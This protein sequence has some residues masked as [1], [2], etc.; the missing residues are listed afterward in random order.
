MKIAF[1]APMKPPTDPKPS[2]DRQMARLL[3]KALTMAGHKV[4]LASSLRSRDGKGDPHQQE[5]IRNRAQRR[6]VKLIESWRQHPAQRPDLWFTYHLYYKA[7]D[8][9]GPMVADALAIPY[10]VAEAS[11][12]PKRADGPWALNYQGAVRAVERADRIISLNPHNDTCVAA[13]L[14]GSGR[15]IPL[16]PFLD[17]SP[18]APVKQDRDSN[19]TILI[20]AAMMREGDKQRSYTVLAESL[21]RLPSENWRLKIIG[22]GP[23]RSGI[24]PMFRKIA[25]GRVEFLG[26]RKPAEIPA[27]LAT[28]DIFVWPAIGEAYGMALLEAQAA[29]LPVIAGNSGGVSRIV[30]DG[31]TGLLTP[32]GDSA[33]FAD[34]VTRLIKTPDQRRKMGN[35]ALTITA[36][37]HSLAGAANIL[38]KALTPLTTKRA[39]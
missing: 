39:A 29:G 7:P 28:A 21:S 13:H 12:A 34:A 37:D 4:T 26:R 38:N 19:E 33:A 22:D 14:G 32:P 35:E 18:Y 1:Y 3:M 11:L 6:A 10:V 24:E 25:G 5:I 31:V 16:R 8:W 27:I 23:A 15:F 20:T 2:G 30:R 36:R 17:L 9:I